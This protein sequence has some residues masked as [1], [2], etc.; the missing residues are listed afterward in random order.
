MILTRKPVDWEQLRGRAFQTITGARFTVVRVTSKNVTIRPERG[1]RN[2][3]ISIQEELERVLD[4]YAVGGFF[5]SP[6]ELLR[7][8]VRAVPSS[9]AWAILHALL[10]EGAGA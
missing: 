9:Y 7:S 2:Y 4:G 3:A 5:P 6:T 1:T 10:N 8:G